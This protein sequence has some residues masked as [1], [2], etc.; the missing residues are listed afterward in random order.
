MIGRLRTP[1]PLDWKRAS[2]ARHVE[3]VMFECIC[4]SRINSSNVRFGKG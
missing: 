2:T 3:N 4:L 1:A